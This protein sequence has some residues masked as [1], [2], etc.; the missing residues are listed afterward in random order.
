MTAVIN[1]SWVFVLLTCKF[2]MSMI[3]ILYDLSGAVDALCR[4]WLV[5]HDAQPF[6]LWSHFKGA[7][8]C[9]T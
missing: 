2:N 7:D 6:E 4:P 5:L 3:C 9:L 1:Y 8:S